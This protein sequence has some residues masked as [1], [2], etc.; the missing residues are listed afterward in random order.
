MLSFQQKISTDGNKSGDPIDFAWKSLDQKGACL[1]SPRRMRALSSVVGKPLF[2]SQ[3]GLQTIPSCGLTGVA[4]DFL[5]EIIGDS[6][7]PVSDTRPGE[8]RKDSFS[9][10]KCSS[11]LLNVLCVLVNTQKKLP[12]I[13]LSWPFVRP[14]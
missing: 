1:Q 11:Q 12:K 9:R 10:Y 6:S 14:Q 4:L 13:Y 3:E 8:A 5:K 7:F 2:I